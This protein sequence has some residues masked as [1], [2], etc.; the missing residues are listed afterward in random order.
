MFAWNHISV[1]SKERGELV[2]T[3]LL[4]GDVGSE[5]Y[6]DKLGHPVTCDPMVS[7]VLIKTVGVL[8][9]TVSFSQQLDTPATFLGAVFLSMHQE[10]N[11]TCWLVAGWGRVFSRYDSPW[12]QLIQGSEKFV[13]ICCF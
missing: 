1:L 9:E 2:L 13:L 11:A 10:V 4:C 7:S 8:L 5:I 12:S 3:L 6:Y